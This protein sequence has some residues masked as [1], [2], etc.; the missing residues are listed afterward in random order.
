MAHETNTRTALFIIGLVS[1]LLTEQGWAQ[2]AAAV[3]EQLRLLQQQNQALQ[4]QLRKQQALIDELTRKVSNIEEKGAENQQQVA[5]LQA[6]MKQPPSASPAPGSFS[7]GKVILSGEGGVAFFNSGSQGQ[8][9][10]SE[11]RVDEARLFVEAPIW[12]TASFYSEI[13]LA[14]R[15]E[16]DIQARLGELY[17][18][19]ENI[20]RLW[21][22]SERQLNLRAGRMYIPF[23]EEY[24]SRYSID[25]PLISHSISDLW[26]VDEGVELYGK[27]GK[28][29]YVTAVQNGGI[30]DTRD[31]DGDKSVAGR[32]GF[33]PS[34]WLHLSASGMRTGDLAV[35]GDVLSA[36]W[37]AGGFFR[38]LGSPAT[39]KFHA[40]LVEGDVDVRIPHGHLKAFGGYVNYNDND[41]TADNSRGVYY[42]SVEAVHDLVGRLY[43]GAR[44]SQVLADKGFPVVGNGNMGGYLFGPLT[45]DLWRLSLGLGYRWSENLLVKAE[46]SFERGRLLDGTTRDDEDLFA[47]EAAF[48]F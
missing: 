29:T 23:G 42:Y 27:M 12:G 28:F 34:P 21:N 9:P 19:V 24:M 2:D 7:L 3:Q 33:D 6:E 13:N 22:G 17:L 15:E 36:M 16:P 44:F 26:G 11:F 45:R 31:F 18:D 46:Y 5:E 37:F 25:N 47:A 14:T 39:T 10:H 32:L 48:R 20:S 40:N 1:G 4:E 30:P 38:S 41:P 43:A 8:F 35:Q